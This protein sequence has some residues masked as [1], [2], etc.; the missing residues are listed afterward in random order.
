MFF[1]HRVEQTGKQT[2]K[3]TN[4]AENAAKAPAL[5]LTWFNGFPNVS[6]ELNHLAFLKRYFRRSDPFQTPNRQCQ[7]TK[8]SKYLY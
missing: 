4:A 5:P 1:R 6:K 3:R 8:G 2:D 7:T